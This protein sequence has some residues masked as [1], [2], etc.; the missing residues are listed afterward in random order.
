MSIGISG[1]IDCSGEPFLSTTTTR[2][3]DATRAIDWL[4]IFALFYSR[5]T[6]MR[7]LL[8]PS[9]T[10][11]THT[12]TEAETEAEAEAHTETHRD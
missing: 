6:G 10:A 3:G 8:E 11:H 2:G 9:H 12:H 5:R 1:M 4:F 7:I